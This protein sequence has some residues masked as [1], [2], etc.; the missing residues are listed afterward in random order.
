MNRFLL[1]VLTATAAMLP[2]AA[3]L[4]GN[5]YYRVQNYLTGRW[6]YVTDDKGKV[7]VGATTADVGAIELWTGFDR[8]ASDPA[9]IIYIEK[10]DGSQYDL[11]A[12]GANVATFMDGYPKIITG[13]FPNTYLCYGTKSGASKYLGDI[14]SNNADPQGVASVDA[15]GDCRYWYIHPVGTAAD[16][17]FGVKPTVN[18]GGVNYATMYA[19]FPFSAYS[20]GLTIYVVDR[21]E[22]GMAVIREVS[23]TVPG[24]TPV[25]FRCAGASP[26]QNKLTIG[27]T[28]SAVGSNQ[29]GGVFFENYLKTHQNLTRYDANTMRVLRTDTNG[30]P[31]FVKA[32]D[33]EYLP[34][35]HAYLKV[36]AGSPDIIPMVTED[37]FAQMGT[38]PASIKLDATS[39]SLSIGGSFTLTPTVT[40]S[41]ADYTLIW[42][43]D[44]TSVVTVSD[45]GEVVAVG[46]GTGVVT[47]TTQNGLTA[48]CKVTVTAV[49]TS[50]TVTPATLTLTELDTAQL[51]ATVAPTDAGDKS[52]VWSSS[53]PTVVTVD[54]TGKITAVKAGKG[55]ITATT[56]NGIKGT[57]EVTVEAK[58]YEAEKIQF[59]KS[60]Y[61]VMQGSTLTL[62]PQVLPEQTTDK[63]IIWKSENP[64][65]ATVENGVVTGVS[66]GT[67][68]IVA[69]CGKA[70]A[71]VIMSV[72][73]RILKVESVTLNLTEAQLEVGDE[74]QLVAT[75]LP[76]D[77]TDGD[78]SWR[79]SS[80]TIARVDSKGLV[81]ARR[82]GTAEITV[83]CGGVSATCV[84]TVV[85]AP[86]VATG[87]T[88][89]VN[90]LNLT[91]GE[92]ASLT[93][94][95]E[96]ADADDKSIAWSS[97][98]LS[99]ATVTDGVVT[100]VGVGEARITAACGDVSDVCVVTVNERAPEVIVPTSITLDITSQT[101]YKGDTFRLTAILTPDDVTEGEI[102]WTS[103]N[104]RVAIVA[105]DGSVEGIGK[106]E[107][108]IR[109]TT[110]N[111]LTAT[112]AL[113]VAVPVEG[114]T[115]DPTSFSS[116]EG[117][118]FDIHVNIL[119]EDADEPQNLLWSSSDESVV[120]VDQEGHCRIVGEGNATVTVTDGQFEAHC[121]IVGLSG[122]EEIL[123]GATTADVYTVDGVLV[124]RGADAERIAALPRGLYVVNGR[125]FLK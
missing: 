45:K 11:V 93:A 77:H 63:T 102:S 73:R 109:A 96:P 52:V 56:V 55:T 10:R 111:G 65:I 76:E 116:I 34:A 9:S 12:Q 50:I 124:V 6:A 57:C 32:S 37:E 114:L 30:K 100:A 118:E 29:L 83:T 108:L 19:S 72:T 48:S 23:G 27:G 13:K 3:Q 121:A 97:D 98:N 61:S 106:G 74:L 125:K 69:T 51:T 21:V 64:E 16:D 104:T 89:N 68:A 2:A 17:Y 75:V 44:N 81:S 18:A 84:V 46:I 113:T 67:T 110:V 112:C 35:N 87:V 39:K 99:V 49:P 123:A 103:S 94:E 62:N 4:N 36:S 107:T 79:S 117:T 38:L 71:R 105:P 31:A 91:E 53:D 66:V 122:I 95:V 119:P 42:K 24:E 101:I 70:T 26:E 85:K 59:D 1:S 8:A 25:I 80:G 58:I 7:N 82:V 47:A 41:N 115:V 5:G 33:L 20:S 120:E 28:G 88:L 22:G 54:N 40:P 15:T 78:L 43:S 90:R 60:S 86:V 92:S 14:E